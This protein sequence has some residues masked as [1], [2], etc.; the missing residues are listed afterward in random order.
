MPF[1]R[2][3]LLAVCVASLSAAPAAAHPHVTVD[4]ETAV[5]F[6]A[7]QVAA[8]VH[9]WTFDEMYSTFAIQ[10]LDADKDGKL[11]REELAE[12]TKI[13][14]EN[15]AERSFFTV[16][17][18]D[19]RFVSFGPVRDAWSE[20]E[21]GKLKLHFTVP[22]RT[23][24]ATGDKPVTLEIYD[25]EYFVAFGPAEGEPIRLATA[26]AGCSV[27]Y[28][29]PRKPD[30]RGQVLSESFFQA[31]NPGQNFGQQ[32]AGRFTVNCR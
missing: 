6:E 1:H 27:D 25:P 4:T 26:P 11:S 19:R 10:G 20:V 31:L 24:F 5:T 14:V 2:S 28:T 23:P 7:G 18:H 15:L 32:F 8:L 30:G 29:P 21:G 9:T 12:L 22:I 16:M 17:R 13:N 3:V